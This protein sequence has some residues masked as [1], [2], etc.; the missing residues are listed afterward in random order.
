MTSRVYVLAQFKPKAGKEAELFDVLKA[1][2]PDSLRE[3]GCVQYTL[4]RQ[5]DH[6]SATR[7]DYPIVFNEI[8][9]SAEDWSAHGRRQQIQHFF[10]TQVKAESGLVDDAIVTAYSD[11][12]YN[13]DAPVYD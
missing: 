3:Q 10:E 7:N 13:F 12:G 11:E 5:I 9:A 6:P 2:E 8:W 4:T 1:L